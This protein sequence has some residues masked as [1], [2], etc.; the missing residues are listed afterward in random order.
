MVF[1]LATSCGVNKKILLGLA[2]AADGGRAHLGKHLIQPL[3]GSV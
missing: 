1:G 3:K 2:G